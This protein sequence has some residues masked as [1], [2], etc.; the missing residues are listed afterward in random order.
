MPDPSGEPV[1]PS[2]PPTPRPAPPAGTPVHLAPAPRTQPAPVQRLQD[3]TGVPPPPPGFRAA[4]EWLRRYGNLESEPAKLTSAQT[5]AARDTRAQLSK[6]QRKFH[7]F[8]PEHPNP[9][10]APSDEALSSRL[11]GIL[12]TERAHDSSSDDDYPRGITK[13]QIAYIRRLRADTTERHLQAALGIAVVAFLLVLVAFVARYMTLAKI[14]ASSKEPPVAALRPSDPFDATR[15][16]PTGV[17]D[18]LDQAMVAETAADYAKAIDLLDRAEREAGHIYGLNYRRAY[19]C[20]KANEMTRVVPLLNLSISQ[21]EDVAACYSLRGTLSN[22]AEGTSQEPNDLEKATRLE[23]FNARYFFAWG[24]ALRR[25]GKLQL[26]VVQLQR[27]LDRLQEPVFSAAW[28]LKLR[29]TQIELGQM[30]AFAADLA[31]QMKDPHPS[32]DW[33]LTAAAVEMHRSNFPAAAEILDRV[34]AVIGDHATSQQ[35]QDVF[36]KGFAHETELARFF[37]VTPAS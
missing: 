12:A 20:Y 31:E 3:P 35:M 15:A 24:E 23:P 7:K 5:K 22:Q 8:D 4:L 30:D 9:P 14:F 2:E 1:L 26:A 16:L 10:L 28:S 36:F 17:Q 29:L 32:V 27:A 34:R 11:G 33:L 19:L 6:E 37:E 21:G 13:D 25:A 18:L